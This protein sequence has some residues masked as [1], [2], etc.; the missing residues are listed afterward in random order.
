MTD[1]TVGVRTLPRRVAP[2]DGEALDSWIEAVAARHQAPFGDVLTRYGLAAPHVPI[3]TWLRS[4]S[5]EQTSRIADASGV[6]PRVVTAMT[7]ARYTGCFADPNR[8]RNALHMQWVC[9]SGS[10]MCHRCLDDTDG[11]WQLRWR[12]NWSFA[13]VHHRCLLSVVCPQCNRP[14]RRHPHAPRAIP[15]PGYC[16][17]PRRICSAGRPQPCMA[18]LA[19]GKVVSLADAHLILHAQR[20]IDN[21]LAGRTATLALYGRAPPTPPQVLGDIHLIARWIVSSI[22]QEALAQHLPS[23]LSLEVSSERS[24]P[25]HITRMQRSANLSVEKAAAGIIIALKV[26]AESSVSSAV[27]LLGD[28]MTEVDRGVDVYR[29]PIPE[30]VWLS[31]VARA[32]HDAAYAWAKMQRRTL[33][34]LAQCASRADLATAPS[35]GRWIR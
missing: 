8:Q 20:R 1:A 24:A 15:R 9:Q 11:R 27:H 7:L 32:V 23:L 19:A 10:R 31:P 26:F 29:A 14:Q 33:Y 16:A 4:L 18:R 5:D 12:L 13:C 25:L 30:N 2:T 6:D 17:Q 3:A 21:L 34:R 22:R 35:A 28:L